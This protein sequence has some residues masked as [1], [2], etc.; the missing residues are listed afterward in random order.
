M[1]HVRGVQVGRRDPL[2]FNENLLAQIDTKAAEL[3]VGAV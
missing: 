1:E 2:R 3:E